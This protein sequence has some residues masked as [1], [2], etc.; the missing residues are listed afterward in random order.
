MIR[1]Y[2]VKSFYLDINYN[3]LIVKKLKLLL[4]LCSLYQDCSE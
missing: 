1:D 3:N 4:F 2:N